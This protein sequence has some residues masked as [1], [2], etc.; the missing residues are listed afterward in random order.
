MVTLGVME[1][2]RGGRG[3]ENSTE[4]R[5]KG[6]NGRRF[7][8]DLGVSFQANHNSIILSLQIWEIWAEESWENTQTIPSTMH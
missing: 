8:W 5:G 3:E 6:K 4:N 2:G 1:N 7:M